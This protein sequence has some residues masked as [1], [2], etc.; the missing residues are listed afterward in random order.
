M[1]ARISK[2]NLWRVTYGDI[3]GLTNEE[4]AERLPMRYK[5][6][7]PGQPEPSEYE[8]TN[9]GPYK[10]HQRLAKSMRVGRFLLAGDAAHLCN[11]LYV[12]TY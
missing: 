7:L 8:I 11:P 1:A 9:I 5:E 12:S 6:I 4:Y 10:M 3:P 2:Q